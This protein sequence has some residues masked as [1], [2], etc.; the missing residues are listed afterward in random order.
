MAITDYFIEEVEYRE[1]QLGFEPLRG[2]IP[3]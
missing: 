2:E 1:V 3:V